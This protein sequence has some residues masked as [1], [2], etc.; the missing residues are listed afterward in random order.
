MPNELRVECV[1]PGPRKKTGCFVLVSRERV[2]ERGGNTDFKA[3]GKLCSLQRGERK[4]R[5][6]DK[7]AW[8]QQ[9]KVAWARLCVSV[10]LLGG[11]FVHIGSSLFVS[12]VV[13]GSL[14]AHLC[15]APCFPMP[16]AT[17]VPM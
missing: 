6:R 17:Y 3:R 16:I 10:F 7:A 4:N 14:P 11:G 15:Y 13:Y 9:E 1:A 5:R 12:C 8:R 2:V